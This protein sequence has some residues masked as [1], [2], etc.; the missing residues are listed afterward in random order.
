VH[1]AYQ[2]GAPVL[3]S[4]VRRQLRDSGQVKAAVGEEYEEHRVLP[5]RPR[6]RD[7]QIGLVF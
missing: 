5:R 2:E 3:Q 6:D 4:E 1:R 7:P